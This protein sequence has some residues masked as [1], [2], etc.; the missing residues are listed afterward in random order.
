MATFVTWLG[1][2]KLWNR[3]IIT[4]DAMATFVTWSGKKKLWIIKKMVN[5]FNLIMNIGVVNKVLKYHST[6]FC[7]LSIE[8]WKQ[9]NINYIIIRNPFRG[10]FLLKLDVQFCTVKILLIGCRKLLI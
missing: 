6:L 7:Q 5:L 9:F 3:I 1:K 8:W 4:Q 2:K 10:F